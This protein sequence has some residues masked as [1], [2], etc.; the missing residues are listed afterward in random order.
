MNYCFSIR[1]YLKRV[2]MSSYEY[3]REGENHW[4]LSLRQSQG[5][6][7]VSYLRAVVHHAK[8]YIYDRCS[9]ISA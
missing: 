4:M 7:T 2:D 9:E 8:I 3:L 1:S 6:Y 5:S